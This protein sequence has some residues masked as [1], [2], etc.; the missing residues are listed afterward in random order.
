M[1][2][3]MSS[4]RLLV[5]SFIIALTS[6]CESK[7]SI[8]HGLSEQDANEIVVLLEKENIPTYKMAAKAAGGPGAQKLLL[9]DI[10]VQAADKVQ[11]MAIL[12]ANGL[13]RTYS[14]TLLDLFTAS[15]LV[16]SEMAEKIRYEAGLA[17]SLATTIRK[18]D[19]VVDANVIISFPEENPLN[20]EETKGPITATVFVK[21]TGILDDPNSHISNKIKE[22]VAGAVSGLKY[23]N[24]TAVNDRSMLSLASRNCRPSPE[25]KTPVCL[26]TQNKCEL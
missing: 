11:A 19:G 5:L 18:I 22:L 16:P 23:D 9:W 21:H 25:L 10:A 4:M 20:P 1:K 7:S 15:G 8:V 6:G 26:S 12:S 17:A 14:P 24:V 2:K 3:V 13:P